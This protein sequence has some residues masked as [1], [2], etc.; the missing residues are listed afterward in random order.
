MDGKKL[1]RKENN[2]N[3]YK[4]AM[5]DKQKLKSIEKKMERIQNS[6]PFFDFKF[7]CRNIT[8][9]NRFHQLEIDHFHLKFEIE[10]C[11]TCGKKL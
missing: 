11:K 9:I 3:H 6:M 4:V 8:E 2:T 7:A 10:H 5:T 1:K